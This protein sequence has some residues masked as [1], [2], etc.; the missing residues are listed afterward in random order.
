MCNHKLLCDILLRLK[1]PQH[2]ELEQQSLYKR[3]LSISIDQRNNILTYLI[4]DFYE[5]TIGRTDSTGI[6]L[7]FL[8]DEHRLIFLK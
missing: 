1:I 4:T 6:I 2:W 7:V 8:V 3:T 5:N